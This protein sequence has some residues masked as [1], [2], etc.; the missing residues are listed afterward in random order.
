MNLKSGI[1]TVHRNGKYFFALSAIGH[2][3]TTAYGEV[4]IGLML[5]G[6]QVGRGETNSQSTAGNWESFS[7]QS[8][9]D[10]R[11]GDQVWLWL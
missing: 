3:I 7:L 10:L 2:Y 5:N 8:I 4:D 9:L 6:N 11:V 1:F